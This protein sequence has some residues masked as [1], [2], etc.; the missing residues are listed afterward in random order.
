MAKGL[1]ATGRTIIEGLVEES[2]GGDYVREQI[3]QLV[4]SDGW[5]WNKNLYFVRW[6]TRR[7]YVETAKHLSRYLNRG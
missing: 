2:Y 3:D 6:L 7:G 1:N 4:E 5:D